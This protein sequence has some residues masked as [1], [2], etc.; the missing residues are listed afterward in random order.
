MRY[1]RFDNSP[2]ICLLCF[3]DLPV[4]PAR[5]RSLIAQSP[6]GRSAHRTQEKIERSPRV[7]YKVHESVRL[8]KI[9]LESI[10]R[11]GKS[12]FLEE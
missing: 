11:D 3:S 8:A 7:D 6:D 2:Y 4:D 12:G 10:E 1:T 9:A 5:K